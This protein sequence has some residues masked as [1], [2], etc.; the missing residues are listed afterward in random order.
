MKPE[1]PGT[2]GRNSSGERDSGTNHRTTR[3]E[4]AKPWIEDPDFFSVLFRRYSRPVLG[5]IY[6]LLGDREKA[7]E[8]T[9]ETFFRAFRGLDRMQSGSRMSTWL[10]GIA[11]NVTREAIRGKRRREVDLDESMLSSLHDGRAAPEESFITE[12]L[13]LEIRRSL[14]SLTAD[15]R[16][17]FILKMLNKMRYQEISRITGSSIGKLKTDLHRARQHM[18]RRLQ[19]Y[20]QGQ[21]AGMRGAP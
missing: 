1:E 6:N 20:V 16:V 11:R 19:P 13:M 5:F 9:Q 4:D 17:V 14:D 15:Q 12:E 3:S 10:F 8:L 7:E 2:D 18:R 21:P